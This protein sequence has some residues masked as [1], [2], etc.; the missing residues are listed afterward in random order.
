MP[1]D[2]FLQCVES[3]AATFDGDHEAAEENLNVY[4]TH[5]LKFAAERRAEVRQQLINII[6]CLSRLANRLADNDRGTEP[7]PA[8]LI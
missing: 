7:R 4:E 1:G 3:L 5:A 2:Y 6:G 8:I